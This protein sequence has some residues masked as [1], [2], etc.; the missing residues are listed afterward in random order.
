M[1]TL[2]RLQDIS[3]LSLKSVMISPAI[4]I[5]ISRKKMDSSSSWMDFV[6]E[7][8]GLIDDPGRP[9]GLFKGH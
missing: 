7:F 3:A 1:G 6:L 4:K 8:E 2:H 5:F 9:A